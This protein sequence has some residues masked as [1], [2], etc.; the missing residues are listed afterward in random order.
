MESK[1]RVLI[2]EDSPDLR[3]LYALGLNQ[4]GFEVK[5]A[6]NGMEALERVASERPDII[7]LDLVMPVMDGWEV[8]DKLEQ[9]GNHLIP[10]VVISGHSPRPEESSHQ[11]IVGWLS[12]P[13]S[14][15]E[16]AGAITH[17]LD[18][19][20]QLSADSQLS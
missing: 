16:L 9:N 11:C 18:Q 15:T 2:V 8:M 6:S 14:L 5:L 20:Q 4:K 10:V 7:L 3:R 12:K 19:N 1:K 17:G 13:V